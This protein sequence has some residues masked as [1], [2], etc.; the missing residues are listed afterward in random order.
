MKL[1]E[2]N[3]STKWQDAIGKEKDQLFEYE[4]FDFLD[5]GE[6]APKGY[7]RIPGFYVFDVKHDLRRK[8]R[9]LAGGYMTTA[10]KEET[11]SGVVD[12]EK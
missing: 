2:I 8:A 10:P 9:F 3:E 4:T 11:Y 6:K 5:R 1:D 7:K 12:H